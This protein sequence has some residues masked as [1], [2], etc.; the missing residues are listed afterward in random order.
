MPGAAAVACIL[1]LIGLPI[2]AL[3]V[4]SSTGSV[5]E[6]LGDPYIRHVAWFSFWQATIST[7]LSLALAIPVATALARRR[8]IPFHGALLRIFNL[9]L[10]APAMIAILGIATVHGRGGWVSQMLES[11]GLEGGHYL[12]GMFGILL[13]HVFFNMPLATRVFLREIE[14]APPENWR[15]ASELG[16]GPWA[17]FRFMDWPAMRLVLPGVAG[18]VFMLCF[19]SFAVVLTLGGG[20][21]ATTLEVAIYQA[22]RLDFDIIRAVTLGGVQLVTCALLSVLF[23]FLA[24]RGGD[25]LATERRLSARPDIDMRVPMMVDIFFL[26][27]AVVVVVMPLAA[28]LVAGVNG[29]TRGVLADEALWHATARSVAVALTAG[30]LSL[31]LGLGLT[32]GE[33]S[34]RVDHRRARLAGAMEMM[35]FLPLIT[36]PLMLAAGLFLLLR[37]YVNVLGAGLYLTVLVNA[38]MG[39]PFVLR[40]LAPAVRRADEETRRLCLDLGVTGWN[41]FRQVDWPYIRSAAGL[42]LAIAATLAAGDVGVIALFGSPESETLPLLL[43]RRMGAYQMEAAAVTAT[44]LGALCLLMFW[45]L[46]TGVGGRRR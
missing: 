31:G 42:A 15:L 35:G 37:P 22:L 12:Y 46:E 28:V 19:T 9:A 26:T 17:I 11:V 16:M 8:G 39:L 25:V 43:Y 44:V 30:L 21:W 1:G 41:R 29:T 10:V 38:L 32:L 5:L 13:A 2:L 18:A 45:V 7:V 40:I 36:P 3:A 27:V 23:L 14:N 20:P 34:L 24:R 6:T 4:A 33:R